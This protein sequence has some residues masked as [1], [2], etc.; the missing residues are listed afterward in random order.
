MGC[1][2]GTKRTSRILVVLVLLGTAG[3]SGQ[4]VVP[5]FLENLEGNFDNNIPWNDEAPVR[6]QQVFLGSEV[7]SMVDLLQ[8][9]Y[10][11]DE[12][13]G[14]PFSGMIPDVTILLT[15]TSAGPDSLSMVFSENLGA[16]ATVVY[17][18]PLHLRSRSLAGSPHRFDVIFNLQETFEFDPPPGMNLLM[19]VTIPE[20]SVLTTFDAAQFPG[21]GVSRVFCWVEE[22]C[23]TTDDAMIA[24]T[25]GLVTM[26][27]PELIFEDGFESGDTL[28]WSVT[29]P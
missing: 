7:G 9:R 14:E 12:L 25:V 23:V 8:I 27:L 19:D 21:D 13:Y 15:S 4:V 6:Y 11:Q 29:V 26:F 16:D 24:D 22:D 10:R 18:G 5:G 3:A 1:W 20:S 17:S 2:S 28:Q